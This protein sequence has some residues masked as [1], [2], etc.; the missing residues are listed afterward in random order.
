MNSSFETSFNTYTSYMRGF[1]ELGGHKE[2]GKT[3][4]ISGDGLRDDKNNKA[5]F[6]PFH[7]IQGAAQAILEGSYIPGQTSSEIIA[8]LKT[9]PELCHL[10]TS[11]GDEAHHIRLSREQMRHLFG[12]EDPEASS[13]VS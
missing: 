4:K 1:Y 10:V 12:K 6:G 2:K 9:L 13:K 8:R 11:N 5:P 3:L 7:T